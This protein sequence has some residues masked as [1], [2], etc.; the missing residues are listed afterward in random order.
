M[1]T[2]VAAIVSMA[3]LSVS[4]SSAASARSLFVRRNSPQDIATSRCVIQA[5]H[6]YPAATTGD[7]MVAKRAAAY[8]SC[9]AASGFR[10]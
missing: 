10:A 1:K 8:K 5:L 6:R 2:V 4:F 7:A 3:L 9:M